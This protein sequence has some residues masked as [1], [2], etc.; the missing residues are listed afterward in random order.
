MNAAASL[1][2][3]TLIWQIYFIT[4]NNIFH[5]KGRSQTVLFKKRKG[6]VQ[7]GPFFAVFLPKFRV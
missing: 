1:I 2:K 6:G 5:I 4:P 7:F 3:Y